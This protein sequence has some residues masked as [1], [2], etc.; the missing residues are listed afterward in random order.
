[1]TPAASTAS[2]DSAAAVNGEDAYVLA[3][4]RHNAGSSNWVPVAKLHTSPMRR[5]FDRVADMA[6]AHLTCYEDED[7]IPMGTPFDGNGL[8]DFAEK[9]GVG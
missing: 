4:Y 2:S 8:E 3:K 6:Q 9:V 5:S 1:M 7:H